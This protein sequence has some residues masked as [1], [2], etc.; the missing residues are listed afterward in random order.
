MT[1]AAAPPTT[2]DEYIALFPDKVQ[3]LLQAIRTTISTAAPGAT[4]TIKYRMLRLFYM[5]TWFILPLSK[6]T[7]ADTLFLPGWQF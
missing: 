4:E 5:A 7:S 2:I 3:A 6:I 1:S